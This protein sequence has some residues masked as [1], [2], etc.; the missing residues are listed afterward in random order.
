MDRGRGLARLRPGV[1]VIF[2]AGFPH[3][4]PVCA[5][6]RK[7]FTNAGWTRRGSRSSAAAPREH[8]VNKEISHAR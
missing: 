7:P 6:I 2:Q 5:R 3:D 4:G 8:T 1:E